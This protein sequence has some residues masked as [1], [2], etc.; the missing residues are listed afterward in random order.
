MDRMASRPTPRLPWPLATLALLTLTGCFDL[1]QEVWLNPDGSAKVVADVAIPKS[2]GTLAKVAGGKDLVD[3]LHEQRKQ[4]QEAVAKD[5]NVTE[6]VLRQYEEGE[7]LHLVQELTVKDATKLPELFRKV[8]HDAASGQQENPGAWDFNLE[9]EG[10]DYV[11]TQRFIPDRAPASANSDDPAERAGQAIAKEM[12]KAL[13]AKN[14]V[15]L[16]VHGPGIGETN[17]TVN[18]EKTTVEWKVSIAE[19]MDAPPEGREFRAVV[20][21]GE[22]LW[23]WPVVIGV[24][25]AVLGLAIS[26]ARKRRSFGG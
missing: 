22:P 5:P 2:L 23:L 14:F 18:A 26:A 12:A 3:Q 7:Q 19:L 9:R 6:L 20:H 15:T 16:R 21:A 8:V 10:G 11:F 4:A 25:L 1:V 24:P 17:G 13:F